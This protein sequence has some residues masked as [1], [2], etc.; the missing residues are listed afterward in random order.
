MTL[1]LRQ[2]HLA[3]RAVEIRVRGIVQGVGFR[4]FV[5]RLAHECGLA[6]SVLNDASGVLI[7]ATGR[8]CDLDLFCDRLAAEAPPLSRV[9][10]I[11]VCPTEAELAYE[12]FSIAESQTGTMR[13]LVAP[14]AAVCGSCAAEVLDPFARRYRYPFTNCTHCGPRFSIIE[15]MPYDR[16]Q[17]TMGMFPMCAACGSEF[18]EP[19][20]RR[21]HAQPIA[22]HACGPRAW[23]ERLDGRSVSFDQHSMLDDVDAVAGLLQKGKI[24]AI[25]GLGGFHLACDATNAEAVRCLRA[26]KRRDAKPFALMAR[27][28]EIIRRY[29]RVSACEEQL[30]RSPEAPIVL[31]QANGEERLADGV[32]P[33]LDTLGFMLPYTPLHLLIMRR[34][35]RPVVMTSGNH[36][37]ERQV[38]ANAEARVR[39][40]G[41]A[42]YALFHDRDIANRVDDSVVRVVDGAP[43]V[44]RRARGYAPAAITLPGGFET[45]PEILA[46]GGELK[47]TFCIIKDGAAI[48]SQHQGDLEDASTF[49]DYRK[50][51]RLYAELFDTEPDL[52]TVDR[53]PDYLSTKIGREMA[54]AG[55]LPIASVQHHHAHIAACMAENR[56]P[57]AARPVLG[58]ALDGVGYGD[59]GTIWGG[60]FML[61][62][63][64]GYRRLGTFKPVA[65]IGGA[66]AVREPWRNTYAHILAEMGWARFA[67]NFEDLDLFAFL[68]AKP[69]GMLDRMMKERL[70]APLASS[71]GRLFDAVAAAV[72]LSRERAAHEGQGAMLL[73][74]AVSPGALQDESE[75]AAY[76]FAIP[77]LPGTGLPYIE[78]IGMWQALL[79]D[80]VLKS[81]VAVMAARFHL[82]LADA[83][84][85]MVCKVTSAKDDGGRLTDQV[86]LTGGCF[87]NKVLI[88][89]TAA[90]LRKQGFE[91]LTHS[92][93]PAND[94]GLALGQAVIAAAGAIASQGE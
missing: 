91:V 62:D 64:Q 41:I 9:D 24:V 33:G 15:A 65:M 44:L 52:I 71:C 29:C 74:A 23:L 48:L 14:D 66:Q 61:A 55:A 89:L 45:A 50:N 69:R 35:R 67:M 63:Y 72:G 32:A 30:L 85:Q 79:G 11:D 2:D 22:C 10:G 56:I 6:G 86:A 46:M 19:A 1:A 16:A 37:D 21:F 87:Q 43:R 53:H 47:A 93:V 77:N 75:D 25:K 20:D 83:I 12:D 78:P 49:D 82:G 81:P 39:L 88:E 92:C 28:V 57:L 31:L 60:E 5:W 8:A 54:E 76:P 7:E 27:D 4:P 70:N 51:L 36:S 26:R 18:R 58:V 80:L 38:I 94:G 90:R 34:M 84:A 68:A 42:E 3:I 59:D 17:T 73:E 13:T 40:A